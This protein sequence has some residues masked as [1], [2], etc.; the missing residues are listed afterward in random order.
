[1]PLINHYQ[2]EV[3]IGVRVRQSITD[4]SIVEFSVSDST[5]GDSVTG[6][7]PLVNRTLKA[8]VVDAL[9]MAGK[10]EDNENRKLAP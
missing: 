4:K 1:M 5:D 2:I 8:L 6:I 7:S 10:A 3:E 9:N